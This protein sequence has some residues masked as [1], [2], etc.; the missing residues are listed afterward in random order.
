MTILQTERLLL[1]PLAPTDFAAFRTF[2]ADGELTKYMLFYPLEQEAELHT[3]LQNAAQAWNSLFPQ[4]YEF[5]VLR[6]AELLGTVTLEYMTPEQGGHAGLAVS[7]RCTRKGLCDRSRESCGGV[8]S[9]K[10]TLS[11]IGCL[12]RCTERR[13]GTG[14]ATH[15]HALFG[16]WQPHISPDRRNG[17]R[18]NIH[19][20][21]IEIEKPP[22]CNF[23]CTAAVFYRNVTVSFGFVSTTQCRTCGASSGTPIEVVPSRRSTSVSSA[24]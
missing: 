9:G 24:M 16:N 17:R 22:L 12:L 18:T 21:T 15:W 8:V 10:A 3:F 13:L 23:L 20:D 11:H 19:H 2:A 4:T 5:A 7:C 6:K 14:D 1:R